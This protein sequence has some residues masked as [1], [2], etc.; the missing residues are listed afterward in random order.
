MTIKMG[1]K[2]MCTQCHS[3][4]IVTKA[5]APTLSCCGKPLQLK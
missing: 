2:L 1:T 5:G 3:E 4:F